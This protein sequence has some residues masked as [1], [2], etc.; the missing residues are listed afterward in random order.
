MRYVRDDAVQDDGVGDREA[1]EEFGLNKADL[2]TLNASNIDD[3]LNS[4][5]ENFSI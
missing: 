3:L 1:G 2:V 5:D 4:S